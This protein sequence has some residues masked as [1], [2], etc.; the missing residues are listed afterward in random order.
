MSKDVEVKE[1][2]DKWY[3]AYEILEEW[4]KQ[5]CKPNNNCEECGFNEFCP[6]AKN[7]IDK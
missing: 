3:E 7:L 5:R 2:I 4:S 6:K 1:S